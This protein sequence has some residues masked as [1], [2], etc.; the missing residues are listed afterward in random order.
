MT[1]FKVDDKL[2]SH[3]K[4]AA[5]GDDIGALALWTVAGSWSADHLT[6]GFI[7]RHMVVRLVPVSKTKAFRMASALES[8]GLWEIFTREAGGK[9]EEGWLFHGWNERGRQPSSEQILADRE[10]NASRQADFRE[11]QK[12]A[13][14]AV[15]DTVTNAVGNEAP[16]RPDPSRTSFGSSNPIGQPATPA[17]TEKKQRTRQTEVLE[18]VAFARFWKLYPRKQAKGAA[19]KA[20]NAAIRTG[21]DP[22]LILNALEF[23]VLER[24]GQDPKYTKHPA[25]WLNAKCWDDQP[26]PAYTP[27]APVPYANGRGPNDY[28]SDAH[29]DRFVARHTTGETW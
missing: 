17:A 5:L 11:R 2:H 7:P 20:W 21:T 24:R 3:R 29:M 15:T 22:T 27:P 23:Y 10:A 18:P 19:E 8:V 1:W 12:A 13:R 28:G 14:N 26:D 6:D 4:I 16:T 25:T 9:V